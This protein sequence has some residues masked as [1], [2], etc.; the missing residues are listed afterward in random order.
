MARFPSPHGVRCREIGSA[1]IIP[2]VD[3]LTRGFYPS[4]RE[5]WVQRLQRLARHPTPAGFPK[6]GYVLECED[7]LVGASLVIYSSVL[8]NGEKSIRCNDSSWYVKPEFRS[9]ASMLASHGRGHKNVTYF[10]VTPDRRTLPIL[11]A[12]R[13]VRYSSGQFVALPALCAGTAR[14]NVKLV[15]ACPNLD[16]HLP[17]ADIELLTAHESYGCISVTC[18]SGGGAYPFVFAPRRKFG[19][20]PHVRLIYCRDLSDFVRFERPLGRFLAR[21]NFFLAVLDSNGPIPGLVGAYFPG[22]PKY[23]KGPS[24]PRLGD[25]AYSELAMFPRL[26]ESTP[27]E[28]LVKKFS[29]KR[30]TNWSGQVRAKETPDKHHLVTSWAAL[31]AKRQD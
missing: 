6:Y 21:R 15:T 16:N 30:S 20:I 2:L 24:R 28:M 5:D 3:L 13:Y 8:V 27:W 25:L 14:R 23:F 1:D 29:R 22:H 11:E 26:G 9:Y 19:L 10:N 18:I 7:T 31:T 17:Q 12:Q 4:R